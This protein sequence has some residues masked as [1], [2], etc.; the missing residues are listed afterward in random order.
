MDYNFQGNS[1]KG[2][3][4][5]MASETGIEKPIL[6]PVVEKKPVQRK[7]KF[8]FLNVFYKDPNKTFKEFVM[9]DLV[10]PNT[11]RAIGVILHGI[12]TKLFGTGAGNIV[13][14]GYH[15]MNGW[16]NPGWSYPY[17]G[18]SGNVVD[19]RAKQPVSQQGRPIQQTPQ[20]STDL[21]SYALQS[22]EDAERVLEGLGAYIDTYD[23]VPVSAFFELIGV[24]APYTYH[25]FGWTNIADA[26]VVTVE[27]GWAIRFPKPVRL[28]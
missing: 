28:R 18:Q 22:R 16:N 12:V 2:R 26:K 19:F 24:Q 5:R 13:S 9:Q 4:K 3:Q 25:D 1:H 7:S 10:I 23:A 6:T 8:S 20:A 21:M 15:Y 14:S 27:N 11:Q 17:T